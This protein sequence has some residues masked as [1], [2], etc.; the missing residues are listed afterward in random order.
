MASGA[1]D[2]NYFPTYSPDGKWISFVKGEGSKGVFARKTSDIYSVPRIG[3]TPKKLSLNTEGAMDSWHRWSKDGTTLIFSS[4]RS[5]NMTA[6]FDGTVDADGNTSRSVRMVVGH[7]DVK[8]NIPELGP[9]RY[10]QKNIISL[11][12]DALNAIYRDGK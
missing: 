5:G 8:V 9:A 2:Y 11:I 10:F 6:L 3:G 1:G 4:K 7:D 12:S